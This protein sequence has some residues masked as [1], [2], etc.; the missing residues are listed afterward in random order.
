MDENSKGP[1]D[2]ATDATVEWGEKSGVF[3]VNRV[4]DAVSQHRDEMAQNAYMAVAH[5]ELC[6]RRA[7]VR[8]DFRTWVEQVPFLATTF[9]VD[10]IPAITPQQ[11][12]D[13][14]QRR[15]DRKALRVARRHKNDESLQ[16]VHNYAQR[17]ISPL[18][19]STQV[20]LEEKAKYLAGKL[21]RLFL[22]QDF[23]GAVKFFHEHKEEF[24]YPH[25]A[26]IFADLVYEECRIFLCLLNHTALYHLLPDALEAVAQMTKLEREDFYFMRENLQGEEE[27]KVFEDKLC[28]AMMDH[29]AIYIRMRQT[30]MDLGFIDGPRMDSQPKI[31]RALKAMLVKEVVDPE[32]YFSYLHQLHKAGIVGGDDIHQSPEIQDALEKALEKAMK[33]GPVAYI[34]LRNRMSEHLFID[35]VGFNYNEKVQEASVEH[36]E[37][38]Y[39][40]ESESFATFLTFLRRHGVVVPKSF[41]EK[42]DGKTAWYKK[43]WHKIRDQLIDL[44]EDYFEEFM[45]QCKDFDEHFL[46]EERR[47]IA[48]GLRAFL[49]KYPMY[50]RGK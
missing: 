37:N 48:E 27:K 13:E 38:W 6:G 39:G 47:K 19:D 25:E 24:P 7:E 21:R 49:E 36:F 23:S 17:A 32:I 42:L 22:R 31:Q 10:P 4:Q 34:L 40:V 28:E 30:F 20:E 8:N 2:Q 3:S 29:P 9:G 14:E 50:R 26:E 1:D 45:A 18:R 15:V 33:V 35:S 12:A 41:E 11:I 46:Q 44:D 43:L 5:Q 16:A